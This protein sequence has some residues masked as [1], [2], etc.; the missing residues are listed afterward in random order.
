[1]VSNADILGKISWIDAAGPE[2]FAYLV[3]SRDKKM[4]CSWRGLR[5]TVQVDENEEVSGG[6]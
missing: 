2:V 5:M 4:G 3:S 6:S 1:M